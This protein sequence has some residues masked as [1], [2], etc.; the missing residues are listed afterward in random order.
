MTYC[1]KIV[2]D[3]NSQGNCDLF[4]SDLSPP[5]FWWQYV[6]EQVWLFVKWLVATCVLFSSDLSQLCI[7]LPKKIVKI[8][9]SN[10]VTY[11]RV[12]YRHQIVRENKLQGNCYLFS[13]S[14][15]A[16]KF[17]LKPRFFLSFFSQI[18]FFLS[19]LAILNNSFIKFFVFRRRFSGT[20][21]IISG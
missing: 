17:W 13:N 9:N 19:K 15:S 5:N 16:P 21:L 6:I 4:P 14:L 1:H 18:F 7:I 10:S 20:P 2:R 8:N 12:H 3:N 11:S